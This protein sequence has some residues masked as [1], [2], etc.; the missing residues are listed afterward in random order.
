MNTLTDALFKGANAINPRFVGKY[1]EF[2]ERK[3]VI[4]GLYKDNNEPVSIYFSK[5]NPYTGKGPESFTAILTSRGKYAKLKS[6]IDSNFNTYAIGRLKMYQECDEIIYTL[7]SDYNGKSEKAE[8]ENQ[9]EG[10]LEVT[11]D[12]YDKKEDC[13]GKNK[14]FK[15]PHL[16][17]FIRNGENIEYSGKQEKFSLEIDVEKYKYFLETIYSAGIPIW[18]EKLRED[19]RLKEA[20]MDK[21]NKYELAL[22]SS[23]NNIKVEDL[24]YFLSLDKY[25]LLEKVSSIKKEIADSSSNE[26][27]ALR[28]KKEDSVEKSIV[29]LISGTKSA[30]L[31]T[32]KYPL[33]E[34]YLFKMYQ[35]CDYGVYE[36]TAVYNPLS[37]LYSGFNIEASFYGNEKYKDEMQYYYDNKAIDNRLFCKI[38]SS[39]DRNFILENIKEEVLPSANVKMDES[40]FLDFL[41][42]I[43]NEGIPSYLERIKNGKK[44][45]ILNN[46]KL[47]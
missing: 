37:S 41:G 38:V 11:I 19:K 16:G 34:V 40:E 42:I 45:L 22:C 13:F 47:W 44:K 2:M 5:R 23:Q 3:T 35:E 28:Y 27:H 39:T 4:E 31:E 18:L 21:M 9:I 14:I 26:M 6:K 7:Y 1:D 43:Y 24:G 10:V 25:K 12:F 30:T 29:E 20:G 15:K 46:K 32:T 17:M 36:L 8:N 33:G